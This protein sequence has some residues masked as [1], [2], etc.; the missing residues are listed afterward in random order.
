MDLDLD[1]REAQLVEIPKG[2]GTTLR[3]LEQVQLFDHEVEGEIPAYRF[4]L[5]PGGQL[6]QDGQ[7][8][9]TQL[10]GVDYLG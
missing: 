1:G 4:L 8:T 7:L 6:A 9:A 10:P 2:S 5:A 3:H